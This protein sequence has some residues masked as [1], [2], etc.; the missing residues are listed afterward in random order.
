MAL[1][2]CLS[3]LFKQNSS[4][5]KGDFYCLNCFSSYATK[6]E[7]KE[8]EEICNNHNSCHIEMPK[9]VEKILKY[10]PGEKSLKASFAI[11]LDFKKKNNLAKTIPKNLPHKKS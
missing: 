1:S 8:H 10:N 2:C 7:F 4:N 5:H 11:Y 3:A 6:N 9:W